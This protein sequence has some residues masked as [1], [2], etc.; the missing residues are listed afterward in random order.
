MVTIMATAALVAANF[1]RVAMAMLTES[2]LRQVLQDQNNAMW[3]TH[4]LESV[5]FPV[6]L[7]RHVTASAIAFR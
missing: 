3:A 6:V 1:L 4:R 2:L 5:L 7:V